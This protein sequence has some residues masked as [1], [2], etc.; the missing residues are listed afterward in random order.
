M[1]LSVLLSSVRDERREEQRRGNVHNNKACQGAPRHCHLTLQGLYC[2]TSNFFISLFKVEQS[3]A[4]QNETRQ[5]N[6]DL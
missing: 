4:S 2:F 5:G 6:E 1:H 3:R